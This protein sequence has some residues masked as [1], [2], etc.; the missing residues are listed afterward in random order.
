MKSL[1]LSLS[2]SLP[3]SP[4][5]SLSLFLSFFFPPFNGFQLLP[6]NKKVILKIGDSCASRR[7]G[8]TI[9]VYFN[10]GQGQ[11]YPCGL[12]AGS[13]VELTWLQL[14]K[15]QNTGRLYCTSTILTCIRFLKMGHHLAGYVQKPLSININLLVSSC[16]A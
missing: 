7:S 13:E 6:G 5:L 4:S 1:S 14:H 12:C 9:D 10:L 2:L 8:V 11:N 3:P 16:N 15:T